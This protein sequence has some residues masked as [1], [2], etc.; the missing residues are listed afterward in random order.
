MIFADFADFPSAPQNRVA[1]K[2]FTRR[3]A[4]ER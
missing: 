2:P 3:A 4:T 1:R